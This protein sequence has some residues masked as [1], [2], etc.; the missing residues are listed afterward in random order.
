VRSKNNK[1]QAGLAQYI[2][3][4]WQNTDTYRL[5]NTI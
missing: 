1:S 5:V 3:K 4:V 2:H